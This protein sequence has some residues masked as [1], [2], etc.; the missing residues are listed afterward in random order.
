MTAEQ[1][2]KQFKIWHRDLKRRYKD[3]SKKHNDIKFD[4]KRIVLQ[5]ELLLGALRDRQNYGL[6]NE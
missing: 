5:N 3:L 6:K 4:Y 1:E 2:L